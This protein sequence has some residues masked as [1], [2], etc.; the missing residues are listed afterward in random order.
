[1]N[2]K[3]FEL[4]L[5]VG[6]FQAFHKGHEY[7]MDKA[8]ELCDTVGIFVGSSQES[9]TLKNPF[10]YETRERILKTV[11]GDRVTVYPLPDIGVGNNSAWGEYVLQNT[12]ERFG[13]APDLL[14]SGKEER[15][16]DWFDG[17]EGVFAS[18]LYVPKVLDIS[19]TQMRD[20]FISGNALEWRKYTNKK[21]WG[22]YEPLR[23]EVIASKDNLETDS[24]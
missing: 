1:M 19:A 11:Y 14:I 24:M 10:S 16:L 4:G 6:R 5:I 21:L 8:L 23:A 12:R 2:K 9:G 7:I 18:E 20:F 22:E 13:R 17:I 3:A 15:R